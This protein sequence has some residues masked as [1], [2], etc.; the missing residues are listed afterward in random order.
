MDRISN[1][2]RVIDNLGGGN[3]L[4]IAIADAINYYNYHSTIENKIIYGIYGNGNNIFTQ[5][6]LRSIIATYIIQLFND[7]TNQITSR[8]QINA[9]N[10]NTEFEKIIRS[11]NSED[12][13]PDYYNLS[14]KYTIHFQYE[15]LHPLYTLLVI[16]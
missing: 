13:T 15:Q 9:D 4:F 11:T 10:L 1:G 5:K 6:Y 2:L 8:G 7:P 16:H 3:C 14:R 12:N